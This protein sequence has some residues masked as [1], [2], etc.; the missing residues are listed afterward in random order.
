M[1]TVLKT[2]AHVTDDFFD[3]EF[4]SKFKPGFIRPPDLFS[5]IMA[6]EDAQMRQNGS[7]NERG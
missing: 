1:T 5:N 6:G 4:R 3:V 2:Y 7:Q